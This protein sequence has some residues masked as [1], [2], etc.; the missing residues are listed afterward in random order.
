MVCTAVLGIPTG[1]SG[2]LACAVLGG[3][4]GGKIGGD[5]G[6]QGGNILGTYFIAV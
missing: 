6:G 2:A 3:T 4:L 1:G 5:K